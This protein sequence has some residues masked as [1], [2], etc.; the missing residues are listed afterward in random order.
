M[1]ALVM[2]LGLHSFSNFSFA[3]E[4]SHHEAA[5]AASHEG[6]EG[7]GGEEGETKKFDDNELNLGHVK[8]A[9]D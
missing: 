6:E 8:G 3:Q 1:V 5:A 7:K 2:V 9:H 4:V